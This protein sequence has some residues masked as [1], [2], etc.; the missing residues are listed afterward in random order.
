MPSD[1]LSASHSANSASRQQGRGQQALHRRPLI[2]ADRMRR[3][4]VGATSPHRCNAPVARGRAPPHGV[5]QHRIGPNG[6]HCAQRQQCRDRHAL[7]D[8]QA[9]CGPALAVPRNSA[10]PRVTGRS[11]TA[12]R[13]RSTTR[14]VPSL[15]RKSS[16]RRGADV[17]PPRAA[18]TA[19]RTWRGIRR[20][21]A[22]PAINQRARSEARGRG[23]A[24]ARESRGRSAS[25]VVEFASRRRL[26]FEEERQVIASSSWIG[27]ALRPRATARSARPAGTARSPPASSPGQV[28][29][30]AADQRRRARSRSPRAACRR[31]DDAKPASR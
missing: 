26:S 19:S 28:E 31:D 8:P 10:R 15:R 27:G 17:R 20:A 29:Q 13:R 23:S 12:A 16:L 11:S 5:A 30:R 6:K 22:S 9:R 7:D 2:G 4:G 1:G 14:A 24:R 18:P 3:P 21:A 25:P